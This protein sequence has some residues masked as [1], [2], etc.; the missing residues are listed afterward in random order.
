MSAINTRSAE[1]IAARMVAFIAA[2][3]VTPEILFVTEMSASPVATA[4][5]TP[6]LFTVATEGSLLVK[7]ASP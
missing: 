5:T 1:G 7:I 3:R 6:L 4:L 2:L